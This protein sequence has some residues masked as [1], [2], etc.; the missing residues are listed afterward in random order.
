M[1][2]PIPSYRLK[3]VRWGLQ[4]SALFRLA[5]QH[6]LGV[7]AREQVSAVYHWYEGCEWQGCAVPDDDF[8]WRTDEEAMQA[9]R[10]RQPMGSVDT[11]TSS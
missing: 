8:F 3:L 4:D 5:E 2:G 11:A 7:F 1:D 9:A 6:D 10:Q